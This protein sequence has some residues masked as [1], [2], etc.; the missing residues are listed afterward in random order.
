MYLAFEP[1]EPRRKCAVKMFPRKRK[2]ISIIHEILAHANVPE[3]EINIA[4]RL[5]HCYD[6]REPYL[7]MEYVPYTLRDLMNPTID[8]R[9]VVSYL[10]QIPRLIKALRTLKIAHWDIRPMNLGYTPDNI[11]K[12]LDLGMAIPLPYTVIRAVL[13][14]DSTTPTL[15]PY[16]PPEFRKSF[17]VTPT[18]DM[19]TAGKTLEFM[20]TR[21]YAET[22]VEAIHNIESIHQVS[23]P[24]S[25]KQLFREMTHEDHAQ[26]PSPEG[27]EQLARRAALDVHYHDLFL[28]AVA[29]YSLDQ[30]P[31]MTRE[32]STEML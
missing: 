3:N 29:R 20:L 22:S 4:R 14:L 19:Y 31:E 24:E 10:L 28:P 9:V 18:Y 16:Y 23:L 8:S 11:I 13:S 12:A 17:W 2:R 5:D 27:L 6:E 15:P 32:K 1:H 7:V 21:K 26:R 25:C 30:P